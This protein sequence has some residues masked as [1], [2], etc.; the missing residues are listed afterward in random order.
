MPKYDYY[1]GIDPGKQGAFVLLTGKSGTLTK[2]FLMPTINQEISMSSLIAYLN[3]LK[4]LLKEHSVLA[5]LE[6]PSAFLLKRSRNSIMTQG[7]EYGMLKGI[8]FSIGFNFVE[9]RPNVWTKPFYKGYSKDI[10]TK[11][12]AQLV[13]EN[14]FH[15]S[16]EVFTLRG[17]MCHTGIRSINKK[18]K[19][20]LIDAY[21]I[22]QYARQNV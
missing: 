18:S 7:I 15:Q 9:I 5:V 13:F 4:A 21:L 11:Q 17:M 8:V 12:K 10:S 14:L 20:G 16:T 6:Q 2:Y 19:E 1:L 3:K 22:A